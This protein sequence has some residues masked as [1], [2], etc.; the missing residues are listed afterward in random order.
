VEACEPG[1]LVCVECGRSCSETDGILDLRP[2]PAADTLLDLETYDE[3]HGVDEGNARGIYDVYARALGSGAQ[4]RGRILEIGAGTGNLTLGLVRYG[5]FAEI[6]CS[7]VSPRFLGRLIDRVRETGSQDRFHA[8]LLDANRLP[9]ADGTFDA[10][11]GHSI[12]HHLLDFERTLEDVLRVLKPGGSAVFG[13][14]MMETQALVFL[15]AGQILA[16]DQMLGGTRLSPS[17][18]S[19]LEIVARR[20]IA[21]AEN[22]RTRGA[23]VAAFEDKYVFPAEH[24]R[25]L[26]RRLGFA[27]YELQQLAPVDDLAALIKRHLDQIL[28]GTSARREELDR[29]DPLLKCFSEF[30]APSLSGTISRPFA[31]NVFRR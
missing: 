3:A 17:T 5:Q 24:L 19:V 10:V 7:D 6:H 1:T 16:V 31:F 27:G 28:K 9:F 18:R 22:L 15:F 30:Y 13:E 20:G 4:G 2:D 26:S 12:L 11:V 8:Y 29:F 23:K 25:V 21:K 14:P